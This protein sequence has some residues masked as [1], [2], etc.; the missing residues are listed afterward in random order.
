MSTKEKLLAALAAGPA[1]DGCLGTRGAVHPVQAVNQAMRGLESSGQ[2]MRAPAVCPGCERR[3]R[4]NSLV[5]ALGMESTTSPVVVRHEVERPWFWEGYIQ[6]R[7]VEHLISEGY[8]ILR[9]ANTASREP[10]I[11]IEAES[12]G[13]RLW[14]SIK[15]YPTSSPYMQAR[16]WFGAAIFDLVLYREQRSDVSLALGLPRGL[17]TYENLAAR[18]TWLRTSMPFTTFWVDGQG[19]VTKS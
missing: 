5:A 18:V 8:G 4:V 7:V 2:V 19:R 6:D 13:R 15:G 17:K 12:D 14:V 9:S 1:C 3:R 16:H 10:G 11:D